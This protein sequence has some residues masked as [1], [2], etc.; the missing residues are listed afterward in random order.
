MVLL[1]NTVSLAEHKKGKTART[2]LRYKESIKKYLHDANNTLLNLEKL[3][4][5]I[6][7]EAGPDVL[8]KMW[9][10]LSPSAKSE[11]IEIYEDLERKRRDTEYRIIPRPRYKKPP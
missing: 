11:I 8:K 9:L 3:L 10:S 7:N 2:L 4:Y 6:E 5:S 1:R